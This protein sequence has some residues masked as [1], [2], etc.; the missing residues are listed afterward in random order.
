MWRR[1]FGETKRNLCNA[2]IK[3]DLRK[4]LQALFIGVLKP[5]LNE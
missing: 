1:L 5:S 2:A 3:E 4:N